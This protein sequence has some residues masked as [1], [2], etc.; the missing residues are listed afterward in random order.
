MP[1]QIIE[2]C[3]VTKAGRAAENEDG[4]S[5]DSVVFVGRHCFAVLDGH[6]NVRTKIRGKSHGRIA[7]EIGLDF[8]RTFEDFDNPYKLVRDLTEHVRRSFSRHDIAHEQRSGFVFAAFLPEAS[9]IVRVGDCQYVI[10]GQLNEAMNRGLMVDRVK[11]EYR[12]QI[13]LAELKEGSAD[14]ELKVR[15][16]EAELLARKH[17]IAKRQM[18]SMKAWQH[19]Y[20]NVVNPPFGYGVIDGTEVPVAL[21][22]CIPV[23]HDA[24]LIVLTSDGYPPQVIRQTFDETEHAFFELLKRDPLCYKEWVAVRGVPPGRS[25]PDDCT[26]VSIERVP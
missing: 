2:R 8:F 17:D 14:T 19:S 1:W 15:T 21:I 9:L 20:R 4:G 18:S 11:A 22:E 13:I 23:P 24:K 16:M 25:R 26:Y 12:R 3:S 7:V 6:S 10:D 5:E